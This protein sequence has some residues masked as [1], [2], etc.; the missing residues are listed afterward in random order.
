MSPGPECGIGKATALYF[1]EQGADIAVNDIDLPSAEKT[2]GEVKALGGKAITVQADV[3]DA[4][5][6][7]SMVERVVEELGG[8]HILVNNAGMPIH[9]GLIEAQTGQEGVW[10][11]W[12][13][14]VVQRYL[15]V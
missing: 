4:R 14:L 1:A 15:F 10:T 12:L 7:D 11:R 13:V 2:A 8:V 3:A 6:V 9:G 5:A